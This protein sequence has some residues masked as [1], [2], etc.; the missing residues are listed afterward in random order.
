[1]L[2]FANLTNS[3][4]VNPGDIIPSGSTAST[5]PNTGV[6]TVN[7]AVCGNG[8]CEAGEDCFTCTS[9][10]KGENNTQKKFVFVCFF[11]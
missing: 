4:K 2:F 8:V 7:I 6:S 11:K 1:V 10:C 9:D 3:K 5:I